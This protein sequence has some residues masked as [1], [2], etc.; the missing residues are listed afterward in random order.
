V[1]KIRVRNFQSIKD[2]EVVVDGLTVITGPN[3]SGKTSFMRAVRGVF[4]NASAGPLVRKGEGH[5]SVSL[6]FDCGDTVTWEKGTEKPFGKGKSVNRY[7]VNGVTIQ[8]VGRGVPPEVEALGVR[9]ISAS[10]DKIWPQIAQQFSGTLFLVDRPG[11]AIAEALAD[12][13]RV[14]RLT[15][16]LRLSEKDRRSTTSELKVR[17]KDLDKA[18]VQASSYQGLE[19]I[20]AR[21]EGLGKEHLNLTASH[22]KV[23]IVRELSGRLKKAVD[24]YTPLEKFSGIESADSTRA[25]KLSRVREITTLLLRRWTLCQQELSAL[26]DF[27]GLALPDSG[28]V[29]RTQSKAHVGRGLLIQLRGSEDLVSSESALLKRTESD[30]EKSRDLVQELLGGLGECPVCDTVW[31]CGH[32]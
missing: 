24:L 19:A 5:L 4:T 3:N 22:R 27:E 17:R 21:F 13:E 7:E 30:Y 18:Q 8:N 1:I 28:E 20:S 31:E 16:A 14:G 15:D 11:S 2:A 26:E 32:D 10:S 12:V 23:E 9:E 6:E 25:D 29:L